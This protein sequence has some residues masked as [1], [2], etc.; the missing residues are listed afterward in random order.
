MVALEN[1]ALVFVAG[2]ITALATGL[3]AIPF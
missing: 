1:L 3:G 2:L